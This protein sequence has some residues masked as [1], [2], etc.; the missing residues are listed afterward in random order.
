MAYQHLQQTLANLPTSPGVY[1]MKDASGVV[2]YVG[3]AQSLRSRVRSYFQDST[4]PH[5]PMIAA[6]LP[7]VREIEVMHTS[8]EVDALVLEN[9]LVKQFQPKY[10]IKLKDDKR[11]PYIRVSTKEAFPRISV[12]R[13]AEK[14]GNKYWGPF[15][16]AKAT[17]DT[18]KQLIRL[19]PIRTCHL[20]LQESGNRHRVC[21]D[22]H[23][24]RCPGPCADHISVEE[25]GDIVDGVRM[26]L[27]GKTDALVDDLNRKMQTASADLNFERA[28]RLR[29][30]IEAIEKATDAQQIDSS[31]GESYDAIGCSVRGS[32]AC[33]QVL[34]VRGG[35]L[36][37][38]EHFFLN[39]V[40]GEPARSVLSAF[41]PQ[42]YAEASYVPATVVLPVEI[43]MEETV[44][45]WL[46]TKRGGKVALHVARRG[47]KYEMIELA[48]R[49]AAT[50][51]QQREANVVGSVDDH[52]AL[53]EL[54]TM[55]NLDRLP[56]RIEC[57]DISNF[58]GDIIVGSMV[59]FEDGK[60]AR[61]EYRRFRVRDIEGPDDYA[62]MRQVI[63]RRFT[64]GISEGAEM[65]NL[66]IIDGGKGQLNAASDALQEIDYLQ[67]PRV[68]L[69]KRFEHLFVPGVSDPLILRKDHPTLHMIQHIRNEAHRFAVTYLRT[70]RDKRMTHSVLDEIP[71]IGSKRKQALLLHFGDVDAVRQA[72]LDDLMSVKTITR[73]VAQRI[74]KHL[75]SRQADA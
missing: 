64:R 20:D 39:D 27:N 4:D 65:P 60:P 71:Q 35:K 50:T 15:V 6:M 62:A 72:S 73:P 17:R 42:Y 74:Y 41:V 34:M 7:R 54:M 69:A 58:G 9:N 75:H 66:I 23:I 33:A 40:E 49:N 21:L 67:Q 28:A 22:F 47:R 31:S 30:R 51:L 13:S 3:K 19:F 32:V 26:F 61:G 12:T 5:S 68:G 14:D 55:L 24:G 37:E 1:L 2:L 36:V 70:I 8:S 29:D 11:Y 59:V 48:T 45:D 53:K 43:D 46:Q 63:H 52:P 56:R 16:H 44:R 38:R 10:N 57:Y 18:I 25:Y